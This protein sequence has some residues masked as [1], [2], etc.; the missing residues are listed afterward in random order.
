MSAPVMHRPTV[1][2][3]RPQPRHVP[4]SAPR[5]PETRRRPVD[6]R[7]PA[8]TPVASR[9]AGPAR[10][11]RAAVPAPS[12]RT[13]ARRRAVAGILAG[14][15][16]AGLVWFFAVVGGN[17]AAATAPEPVSTS[18]VHVRGGETLNSVAERVAPG[19]SRQAVINQLR[20]LNGMASAELAAGQALVAPVYG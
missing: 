10:P 2:P 3:V 9:C 1:R 15:A 20:A 17:F 7:L 11:V 6:T 14:A 19:V 18:V 12:K 13:L 4:A 8:P 5:P 16:L